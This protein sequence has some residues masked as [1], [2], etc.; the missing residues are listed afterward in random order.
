MV[1]M[2]AIKSVRCQAMSYQ[3]A[4]T[5]QRLNLETTGSQVTFLY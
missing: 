2:N 1:D 4:G 3:P 5:D